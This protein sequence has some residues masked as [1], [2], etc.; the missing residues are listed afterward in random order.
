MELR[1]WYER[2]SSLERGWKA[3]LLAALIVLAELTVV[4]V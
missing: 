1:G 3:C 4:A 2:Y